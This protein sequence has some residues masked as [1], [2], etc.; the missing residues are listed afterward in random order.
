MSLGA[1]ELD[2]VAALLAEAET[3]SDAVGVLRRRFP[4]LTVTLCDP[5]DVDTETPFRVWPHVS[6]H[7]VDGSDHCWRLTADPG[8]A[9]GLVVVPARRRAA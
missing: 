8:R 6:L 5:S 2:A 1:D 9:T 4:A 7:L 3:A